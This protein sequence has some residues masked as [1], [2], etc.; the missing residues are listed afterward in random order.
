MGGAAAR[1]R[2]TRCRPAPCPAG[3]TLL[4]VVAVAAIWGIVLAFAFGGVGLIAGQRLSGA[5]RTLV[6]DLRMLDGRARAERTC[7]RVQIDPVADSYA[8]LKYGGEVSSEP[9][10]GSAFCGDALAWHPVPALGGDDAATASR[11]MPRGIDLVWTS[12]VSGRI[13]LSPL[14]NSNA[15]GICLRAAGGR[16][17]WVRVE[18]LGRAEILH[19]C[20]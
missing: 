13:S 5:A 14:G 11:R 4:E 3:A 8:V 10:G 15:G 17:R 19:A 6:S 18:V 12:F 20:P 2:R 16:E 1:S 7:Y 9:P